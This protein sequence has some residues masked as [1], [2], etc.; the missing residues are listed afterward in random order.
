MPIILQRHLPVMKR[1]NCCCCYCDL[2]TAAGRVGWTGMVRQP[3]AFLISEC[4]FVSQGNRNIL[5]SPWFKP[6]FPKQL[7]CGTFWC[8]KKSNPGLIKLS[9]LKIKC[10][11]IVLYNSPALETFHGTFSRVVDLDRIC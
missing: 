11:K 6:V 9:A 2:R 3:F 8:R 1:W 10:S 4:S 7:Y 5:F